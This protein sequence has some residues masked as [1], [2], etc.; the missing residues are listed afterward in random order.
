MGRECQSTFWNKSLIPGPQGQQLGQ[1]QVWGPPAS[2]S[3][4]EQIQSS[5]TQA[6]LLPPPLSQFR[7]LLA[8]EYICVKEVAQSVSRWIDSGNDRDEEKK[9]KNKKRIYSE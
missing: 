1:G 2:P 9:K 7:P 4:P 5:P 3:I 8:P 6:L